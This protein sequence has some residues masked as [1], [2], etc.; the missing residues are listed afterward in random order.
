[1]RLLDTSYNITATHHHVSHAH[2]HV[3]S[4]QAES[5][6]FPERLHGYTRF[7]VLPW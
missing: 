6:V 5:D 3:N 7:P 4:V 2:E 1:M